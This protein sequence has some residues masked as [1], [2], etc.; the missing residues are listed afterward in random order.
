MLAG[1]A[2]S[3]SPS[4]AVTEG[5]GLVE[6]MGVALSPSC[7]A[8]IFAGDMMSGEG[9]DLSPSC[10]IEEATLAAVADVARK[11]A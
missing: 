11:V 1:E 6:G 4:C 10:A 7:A 9:L 5:H 2:I 8:P 3:L